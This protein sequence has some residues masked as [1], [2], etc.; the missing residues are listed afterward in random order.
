VK[1]V[2]VAARGEVLEI[3]VGSGLNLPLYGQ[4]VHAVCAIDPSPELLRFAGDRLSSFPSRK[5]R[6]IR[7]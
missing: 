1:E 3:G 5:R 2:V 4:G 6:S 7:S